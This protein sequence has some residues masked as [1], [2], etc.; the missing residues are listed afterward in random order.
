MTQRKPPGISWE[1]WSEQAI[2]EAMRRGE[3][4]N[5]EGSGRPIDDLDGAHD[6]LWWVRRKLRDEDVDALP[7]SLALRRDRE[8]FLN[9]LATI[10]DEATVRRLTDELNERI[11]KLNRYGA[12]GPPS[13]LTVM[14]PERIVERWQEARR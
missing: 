11:R 10:G 5:L 1:S 7:P 14:D 13:T 12:S 3:F 6:E 8:Q 4:D 2:A 9:N